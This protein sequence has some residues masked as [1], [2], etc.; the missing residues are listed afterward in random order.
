MEKTAMAT[1]RHDVS[2]GSLATEVM[3]DKVP[4]ASQ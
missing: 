1:V 3:P 4:A 2:F